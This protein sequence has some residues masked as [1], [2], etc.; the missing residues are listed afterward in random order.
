MVLLLGIM[1][2]ITCDPQDKFMRSAHFAAGETKAQ[3]G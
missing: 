2:V 3:R 1:R